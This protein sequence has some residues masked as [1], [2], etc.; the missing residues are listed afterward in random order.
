[1]F[2]WPSD[3]VLA[4]AGLG[5]PPA[6][7]RV[8]GAP[9]RKPAAERV[10]GGVVVRGL[11]A[12]P[13]DADATVIE[14]RIAGAPEV[15]PF[16]VKPG[17]DG[18]IACLAGDASVTGSI[19]YEERFRNLGWWRDLASEAS[20]P[21]Q[22]AA[23]GAFDATIEYAAS[24]E[25]GG[26]GEWRLRVDGRTVASGTVELPGRTDWGDFATV[27]LGRIELPAGRCE[28]AMKASRKNG[29]S[30]INLRRIDLR[31]AAAR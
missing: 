12:A 29:D 31:P 2:E 5:N 30:F 23:A 10:P 15:E 6:G 7:A 28:L 11:G 16:V 24:A 13:V 14:L 9:D 17:E 22:P 25:C 19:Q 26:T 20:W 4:L 18:S 8:L 21:L 1:V 27:P 3:G